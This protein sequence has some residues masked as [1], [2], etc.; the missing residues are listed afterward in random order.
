MGALP[1]C[2]ARAHSR[3]PEPPIQERAPILVWEAR[4]LNATLGTVYYQ[5]DRSSH[6]RRCAVRCRIRHR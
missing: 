4:V 5:P 2:P 1:A 3:G 6:R